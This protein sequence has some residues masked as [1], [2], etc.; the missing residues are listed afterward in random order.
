MA[1]GPIIQMLAYSE[2]S[3]IADGVEG[4]AAAI[5]CVNGSDITA[6]VRLEAADKPLSSGRSEWT[7][8]LLV[9]YIVRRV[10]AHVALRLDNLQVVNTFSDGLARYEH[11]WLRKNDRDMAS[12][13]WE[14][15]AERE[16]RGWA[17]W[18]SCTSWAILRNV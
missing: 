6:I 15:S 16:R 5:V 2:G 13:A 14:L 9:L 4:S 18:R 12:L 10:Q 17:R 1:V 8:L 7:G 11:N 3:A